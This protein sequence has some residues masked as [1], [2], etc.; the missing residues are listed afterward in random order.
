MQA[1]RLYEQHQTCLPYSLA[2][3]LYSLWHL[4]AS[5]TNILAGFCIISTVCIFRNA[6]H[7]LWLIL[8]FEYSG[9]LTKWLVSLELQVFPNLETP[10]IRTA[11]SYEWAFGR[12]VG[13]IYWHLLLC[14]NTA[15]Q[16]TGTE[17]CHNLRRTCIEDWYKQQIHPEH[18]TH[19]YSNTFHILLNSPKSTT[20]L[21]TR[22]NKQW[23]IYLPI[24]TY[25]TCGR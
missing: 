14:G 1:Q 12:S 7:I 20:Y 6:D 2:F 16:F 18:W 17:S 22:G 23:L 25:L 4:C 24:H 8:D 9:Q 5:I 21:H 11:H 13:W 19:I 10:V 3:L 15:R